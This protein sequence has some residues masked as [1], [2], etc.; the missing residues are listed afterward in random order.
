MLV[1]CYYTTIV[2]LSLLG[3]FLLR[4]EFTLPKGEMPEMLRG[5]IVALIVKQVVFRLTQCDRGSWRHAG[6]AEMFDILKANLIASI[7]FGLITHYFVA[8]SFPRSVFVIDMLLCFL[9][10]AGT[11]VALRFYAEILVHAPAGKGNTQVLIYGAGPAA[12]T[13]LRE[14][15]INSALPYRVVGVLTEN[16]GEPAEE[17]HGVPVVGAGR[18]VAQ[19]IARLRK[20][21]VRV[22]EVVIALSTSR[23]YAVREALAN[24]RAAG[25]TCKIVPAINE[26][27]S[28]KVLTQQIREVAVEDLLGREPVRLDEPRIRSSIQDRSVLVTGGGGSI[29]SELCRQIAGFRPERLVILDRAESDLFRI[30][31]ELTSRWP[32]LQ[33]VPAIAD[34]QDYGQLEEIIQRYAV[35]SVFHAAAYKHVPIM[36]SHLI[37]AMKNNVLGTWNAVRASACQGVSSFLMISTDKAVNPMSIM[38]LSKR[39]AEILVSSQPSSKSWRQTRFVSV[40]FGNVLG[41]NGS[42]IPLFRQQISAGG[43]VTVTHPEM[44]RYFMTIPEAIQLVLQASTMGKGSEIFVLNMGEPV[45]IVDLAR[46]MIRLSGREPDVDIE[47][48]FTGLRPGE[49]LAEEISFDS[50]TFRQTHHEDIR[51]FLGRMVEFEKAEAWVR[52]LKAL[53]ASGDESRILRHARELAPEYQPCGNWRTVL[54]QADGKQDSNVASVR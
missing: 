27:L 2:A 34:I 40:R 24:C 53:L 47:I 1:F 29:G 36:E 13:L 44:R 3:A 23:G 18:H 21:R 42:V 38:G 7:S 22:D 26:I 39:L 11:R 43:P 5:L 25:V 9:L 54:E 12:Q 28:G 49:K 19:I 52:E 17:I 30:H 6:L 48:R 14:I 45:K 15:R 32:D 31:Y 16:D 35:D 20:R 37:E 8:P 33:I 4:F 51:I 10:T 50:E 46:N 41:S